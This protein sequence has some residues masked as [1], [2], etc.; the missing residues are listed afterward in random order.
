MEANV[1]SDAWFR[2]FPGDWESGTDRYY[3]EEVGAY[4]RLILDYYK[5]GPL[6]K[7]DQ[8][9]MQIAKCRRRTG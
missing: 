4:L 6:P 1:N 8:R 2:F 3:N 7:D 9:L 5:N